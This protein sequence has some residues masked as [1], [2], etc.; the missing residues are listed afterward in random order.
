MHIKTV[1]ITNHK[2]VIVQIPGYIIHKWNLKDNDSLEVH[3]SEDEKSIIIRPRKG[4]I[5]VSPRSESA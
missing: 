5:T 4:F 3:V 2:N 1:K